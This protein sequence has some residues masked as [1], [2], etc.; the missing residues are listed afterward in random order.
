[1]PIVFVYKDWLPDYFNRY[2]KVN[3]ENMIMLIFIAVNAVPLI[4]F[5]QTM[6]VMC[7]ILIATS[8]VQFQVTSKLI[9]DVDFD[10]SAVIHQLLRKPDEFMTTE[11]VNVIMIGTMFCAAHYL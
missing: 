6:F 8:T 3:T 9:N 4:S 1:M 5:K 11:I 2:P 10:K 7:P